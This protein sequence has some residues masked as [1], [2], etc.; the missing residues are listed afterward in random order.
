MTPPRKNMMP[1]APAPLRTRF[2]RHV[3]KN[4]PR[5]R[6]QRVLLAVSGGMDSMALLH[7]LLDIGPEQ[8]ITPIV[9]HIDHNLRSDSR[10]D[11]R[12]VDNF[13]QEHGLECF[14]EEIPKDLWKEKTG[15]RE[16][17]ARNERYRILDKIAKRDRIRYVMTAHHR[18]DQ[19]ETVL[20]RILDRGSGLRGLAGISEVMVRNSVSY[21]RPLLPFPRKDIE[22]FM[23]GKRWVDDVTN[24]DISFRRNLFR[25]RVIPFLEE[26][27]G[28]SVGDHVVQL[29]DISSGYDE[30]VGV[31]LDSF[32]DRHRASA[33]SF[34]YLLSREEMLSRSDRFWATALAHLIKRFRGQTF[35]ARA[36][37][38]IVGFLRGT[39]ERADY[40]PLTIRN[41]GEKTI[42]SISRR[43]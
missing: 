24:A 27:L 2:I 32:W 12:F 23:Q 31:A 3:K 13:C 17:V 4:F 40:Y 16:E 21:I 26:V 34:R 7:L 11:A 10:R 38:D 42:I 19:V 30:V 25:H 28:P 15:N 41:H 8:G 37:K 18:D 22:V 5:I 1:S 9:A 14:I 35:G 43:R 39:A 6:G 29:S 20:M 33:R 36:M